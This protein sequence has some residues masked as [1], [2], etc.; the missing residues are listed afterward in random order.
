MI[1]TSERVKR[2]SGSERSKRPIAIPKG[3]IRLDMGE[4]DF[5]TPTHIQ[6]AAKRAVRDNRTHYGSAFGEPALRE[7]ICLSLKRDYGVDPRPENVLVTSGGIEAIHV[8]SATY[9]NPGDEA[10]IP[11]PEY[12]AYADS[13]ALF[14]GTP[15]SFPLKADFHVDFDALAERLSPRTK[16]MFISSPGN[17]T[18]RV[19]AEEE[20]RG[21]A[22]LAEKN[23]FLLVL[24]EA[25]HKLIFSG[26]RFFSIC[27]LEA[28][29]E[30]TLL[31][32]SFSKTYAMTGWR[33]GY[34]VADAQ[35]IKEMVVFHKALT[36]C[37]NVP[38][39]MAC[40]AAAAG[41]QEC[42]ETMRREYEKR[43]DLVEQKLKQIKGLHTP[44]CEGAFYVFPRF[45]H[46]LTSQQMTEYLFD[47][48]ILVRSGTEFGARGQKHLRICFAASLE[49][50]EEG[51]DRFKRALD[52]LG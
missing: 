5:P 6:E 10:L 12:S 47:K 13:V 45:E 33:V 27:R 7:A 1:E 30:R 20:I 14:G 50:L 26:V 11:D 35:R 9:L 36:I 44:P 40:A 4:P 18:G 51:M 24:D 3:A 16:L 52:A 22:R 49:I 2:L 31:L 28:F 23:D 15:V 25:Y 21:L 29:A 32:N 8:I 42:V 17:P 34:M 41:S 43:R 19:L 46:P 48:G 37:P 39:Q 38:A